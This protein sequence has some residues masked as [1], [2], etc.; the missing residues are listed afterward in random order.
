M[1]KLESEYDFSRTLC[2]ECN[3]WKGDSRY[4]LF[5]CEKVGQISRNRDKNDRRNVWYGLTR[6]GYFR[7]TY[8]EIIKSIAEKLERCTIE[9]LREMQRRIDNI[10][11]KEE[12]AKVKQKG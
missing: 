1:K 7:T 5:K 8:D 12:V 4:C 3:D 2:F 6:K 9:D 11:E 10:L